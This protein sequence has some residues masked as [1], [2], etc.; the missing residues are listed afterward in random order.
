MQE[1]SSEKLGLF[2]AIARCCVVPEVNSG[3]SL[4]KQFGNPMESFPFF[5]TEDWD[6]FLF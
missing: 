6:A 1:R 3:C 2:L 4:P 5:F